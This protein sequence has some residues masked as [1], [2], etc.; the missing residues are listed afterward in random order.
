MS[1]LVIR[2]VTV[3]DGTGSPPAAGRDVVI[4]DGLFEAIRPAAETPADTVLDGQGG[5]LMPGLWE[6]H[7]H[8]RPVL[9]DDDQVSQ[10][11]LDATLREYLRHGIT[12]V[13]DL[14]G[15]FA[16]YNAFR[17]RYRREGPA[18]RAELLFAGPSFTGINGWPM[19]L[20][21]NPLCAYEVG[22]AASAVAKLRPLLDGRPDVI[23]VIYDGERGS[24]EKI[25]LDALRAIVAEV[26]ERGT[27]V[28]VHVVTERDSVDALEAGADG[29]EHSFMPTP[30]REAE[31][32]AELTALLRTT[33][34]CLTPTLACWE[35][36]GRAGDRTY[37]AELVAAGSM[38]EAESE[39]F[40]ERTP[41]WGQGEF[42]HHPK[43][44]CRARLEAVFRMM[45]GMQ[46]AGV[47]WA[48]GSDIAPVLSRPGATLRELALLARAGVPAM[49]AVLAATRHAAEKIGRD[50]TV[51]TI[52][53]GKA[54]DAL[55]L[56]ANPLDD[57]GVLVRPGHLVNVI[58]QGEVYGA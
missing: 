25:S 50:G 27:H 40:L 51:G 43:A 21:H 49:D 3:I 30:G 7:T 56:D 57:I 6:S 10:A 11:A 46:A 22:D 16:P 39:A 26:H 45:P 23:K 18:G 19:A 53:P 58:K 37:L 17:E 2:R 32:S 8:L 28:V 42:P 1:V 41:S 14:G 12:T 47:K 9:K 24:P 48:V 5:F 33:G 15:P 4:R 55:L 29:I 20:H 31:E 38:S 35:Q 13:V 36:L 52:E 44:E 34:A 54:A